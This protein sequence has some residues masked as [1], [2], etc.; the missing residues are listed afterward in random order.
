VPN[1]ACYGSKRTALR[2]ELWRNALGRRLPPAERSLRVG[3]DGP[4]MGRLI[5]HSDGDRLTRARVKQDD[6][7]TDLPQLNSPPS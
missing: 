3:A 4:G 1:R 7:H 6:G 5:R 2:G